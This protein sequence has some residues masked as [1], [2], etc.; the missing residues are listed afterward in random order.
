MHV[1]SLFGAA[2]HC[3]TKSCCLRHP[4]ACKRL[5]SPQRAGGARRRSGLTTALRERR[6]PRRCPALL[7]GDER[8]ARD[9]G[10]VLQPAGGSRIDG[11]GPVHVR[12]RAAARRRRLGAAGEHGPAGGRGRVRRPRRELL[13]P[14]LCAPHFDGERCGVLARAGRRDAC[15]QQQAHDDSCIRHPDYGSAIVPAKRWRQ[16]QAAEQRAYRDSHIPRLTSTAKAVPASAMNISIFHAVPAG[17]LGASSSSGHP[18]VGTAAISARRE[19]VGAGDQ[20]PGIPGY[21]A[22]N[23]TRP[24]DRSQ[25]PGVAAPRRGGGGERGALW[26]RRHGRHDQYDRARLQRVCA[27]CV[28]PAPSRRPLHPARADRA[29]GRAAKEFRSMETH[30]A[31]PRVGLALPRLGHVRAP[32][33]LYYADRGKT[34]RKKFMEECV[35]YLGW[36]S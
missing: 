33:A 20:D 30:P 32:P 15:A 13:R 10:P 6:Q 12:G 8:D 25:D 4:K 35:E 9:G 18:N 24:P 19:R 27:H 16:A 3:T 14:L 22:N 29:D 31:A 2:Q 5:A 7:R 11:V 1:V 28:P 26:D 23:L 34:P 36:K 17:S 21:V